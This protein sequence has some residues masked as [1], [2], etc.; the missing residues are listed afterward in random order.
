MNSLKWLN[1]FQINDLP[2][3]PQKWLDS[4]ERKAKR[5]AKNQSTLIKNFWCN[6]CLLYNKIVQ[7]GSVSIGGSNLKTKK[8]LI[9][10]EELLEEFEKENKIEY[11]KLIKEFNSKR[12]RQ[13]EMEKYGVITKKEIKTKYDTYNEFEKRFRFEIQSETIY[14]KGFII[15]TATKDERL[16]YNYSFGNINKVKGDSKLLSIQG[17]F[18]IIT[19]EF[20][21]LFED[22]REY[23]KRFFYDTPFTPYEECG[24]EVFYARKGYSIDGKRLPNFNRGSV[25]GL[26]ESIRGNGFKP[27]DSGTK[28]DDLIKFLMKL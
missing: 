14:P 13:D 4:I 6:P 10:T 23:Y 11:E 24:I 3:P 26:K 22:K 20:K 27:K 25:E 9:T 7:N 19:K 18:K 1:D 15:S 16:F 2:P 12:F 28:K 21:L 17:C 8:N 5:N